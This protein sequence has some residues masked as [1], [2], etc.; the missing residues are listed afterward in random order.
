MNDIN[1]FFTENSILKESKLSVDIVAFET[2]DDGMER[3][4]DA[5]KSITEILQNPKFQLKGE[6][7]YQVLLRLSFALLFGW[8]EG[9]QLLFC[10]DIKFTEQDIEEIRV[11]NEM[12]EIC[13][14][15]RGSGFWVR[16]ITDYPCKN[17]GKDVDSVDSSSRLFGSVVNTGQEKRFAELYEPGRKIRLLIPVEDAEKGYTY[18]IK[19]RSYITKDNTTGQAGYGYYRYVAI[20]KE[21]KDG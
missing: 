9:G 1:V 10:E 4:Q 20:Q 21:R 8:Y 6:G 14:Q 11:F 19:T 12:Q 7:K 5:V 2:F 13:V 16:S 18:M 17:N 3:K 15:R